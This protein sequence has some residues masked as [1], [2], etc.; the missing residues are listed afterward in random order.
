[1]AILTTFNFIKLHVVLSSEILSDCIEAIG[2]ITV[3]GSLSYVLY[4]LVPRQT[5]YKAMS[6]IDSYRSNTYTVFF[7][8]LNSRDGC[9]YTML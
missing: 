9:S 1:M 7:P 2:I 4:S 8:V 6:F 3:Y 5:G